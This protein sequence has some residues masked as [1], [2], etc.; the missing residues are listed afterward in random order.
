MSQTPAP[1]GLQD[2]LEVKHQQDGLLEVKHQQ[3]GLLEVKRQQDGLL[4]VKRQQDGLLEV[5]RQQ[6]GLL[7]VKHQQDGLL[8]MKHQQDGLLEVKH[9]QDGQQ[10]NQQHRVNQMNERRTR[11]VGDRQGLLPIAVVGRQDDGHEREADRVNGNATTP[12]RPV[13]HE[14]GSQV[15]PASGQLLQGGI[16]GHLASPVRTPLF[17][18]EFRTGP[19]EASIFQHVNSPAFL[20]V[21]EA[22]L[23]QPNVFQFPPL[24]QLLPFGFQGLVAS[25]PGVSQFQS[26]VMGAGPV[27]AFPPRCYTD[28]DQPGQQQP[29]TA[30]DTAFGFAG[31]LPMVHFTPLRGSSSVSSSH[32]NVLLQQPGMGFCLDSVS[33]PQPFAASRGNWISAAAVAAGMDVNG[34]A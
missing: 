32:S 20:P 18:V 8:E 3:D 31:N 10:D 33:V 15:A 23:P 12:L 21:A 34:N 9:Q 6:D 14:H 25:P 22:P 30:L 28:V 4:E 5:K 17:P 13:S 16:N 7:E 29:L 2:G 27:P 1:S 19:V 11:S 26:A 24:S